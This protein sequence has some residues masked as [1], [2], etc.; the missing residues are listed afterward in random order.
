MFNNANERIQEEYLKKLIEFRNS[1]EQLSATLFS[2]AIIKQAAE[3][4]NSLLSTLSSFE[5]PEDNLTVNAHHIIL[6]LLKLLNALPIEKRFEYESLLLPGLNVLHF[7]L[8]RTL[9]KL[10]HNPKFMRDL[11]P[12]FT[13]FIDPSLHPFYAKQNAS[14]S[15]PTEKEEVYAPR[16]SEEVK[17]VAVQC[18]SLT[19]PAQYKEG[20]YLTSFQQSP[21]A[22]LLKKMKEEGEE[23]FLQYASQAIV[24]LLNAAQYGHDLQL[25]VDA[26]R[27][28]S[29]MLLDNIQDIDILSVVIPGTC[30]KLMAII[31]Q[32]PEKESHQVMCSTLDILGELITAVFN[33][34]KNQTLIN[35]ES[36]ANI[37]PVSQVA[38]KEKTGQKTKQQVRSEAWYAKARKDLRPLLEKTLQ[39]RYY[40]DWHTR[41]AFIKFSYDVLK[42]CAR[43]LDNCIQ[44]LM[45]M[46][47]LH[48]DDGYDQVANTCQLYMDLLSTAPSFENT[49]IPILKEELYTWMMKLP[50]YLIKR[51]EQEKIN[52]IC[53]VTGLL[54]LLREE[55]ESTLS[56]ALLRASDG[57]MTAL[58]FDEDN[59][60]IMEE[61]QQSNKLVEFQ[62]HSD[63]PT[64]T[65]T[66]P[67]YPKIRFKYVIQDSTTNKLTRLL[68]TIG[69]YC[70]LPI[71]ISHFMRYL[72]DG[73]KECHDPQA[74]FIVHS[75]LSGASF[76]DPD[77]FN[78]TLAV[79]WISANEDISASDVQTKKVRKVATQLFNDVMELLAQ[80]T[81]IIQG[82]TSLTTPMTKPMTNKLNIETE[83]ILTT[84][85]TLKLVNLTTF[86]LG[87]SFVEDQLIYILY[88][89]FSY[90]GSTHVY[91]HTYSLITLESIASLCDTGSIS[92]LAIHNIDYIINAISQ[93]ISVINSNL[94]LP[95]VLK[96]L[97]HVGGYPCIQYL[98]D[99]VEEIFDVLEAYFHN[100][101]L[102]SELCGVLY[103]IVLALERHFVSTTKEGK[104][105]ESPAYFVET[106]QEQYRMSQEVRS[107]IE[108]QKTTEDNTDKAVKSMEE[109]GKYFLEKQQKGLH[110][111]LTLEQSLKDQ[112]IPIDMP[113][114]MEEEG[115]SKPVLKENA[116]NDSRPL[117]HEQEMAK[118]IMM[119]ASHFLT[120]SSPQLRS[121]ILV[122]LTAGVTILSDNTQNLNPFVHQLWSIIVN[123]FDDPQN[124][125]VMN[126]ALLVEK[127]SELSTDFLSEKFTKDLWPK[128][129][130][131]L[132]KG[133]STAMTD[134][135]S[136]GYSIYSLY[137][138]TQFSVIKTLTKI[139]Y[140]VPLK[141][142]LVKEILE[143]T[144]FFF[145]EA[146]HNRVHVQLKEACQHLLHALSMQQPD[147][148]W[149]YETAYL[150]NND[151]AT[152][153][154]TLLDSLKVPAWFKFVNM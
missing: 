83:H 29:Q 14:A 65:A 117:S 44:P 140:N 39:L 132:R 139:A 59:L 48:M 154:S 130:K 56:M 69:K 70:D 7:V 4:L 72:S 126:A 3:L 26:L 95:L 18:L 122:L 147:T 142:G 146:N 91:I 149:L 19:L 125:V 115:T 58:K 134:T 131:V 85:L 74:A 75:L 94:R 21:S 6:P 24:A 67:L 22:V 1:L 90:L 145:D 98:D 135:N 47:L 11:I 5:N 13:Y 2:R 77:T 152:S 46:L 16:L 10:L 9:I 88:P 64:S 15:S 33:D 138:K 17:H 40:P 124:Y 31:Y 42:G 123:R 136:T 144:K 53:L 118:K 96:A 112:N 79:G 99:T 32:K 38:N 151:Y 35:F 60:N 114:D 116:K 41:F 86:I 51:G 78:T 76:N 55:A 84:C 120:A 113:E 127:I 52:A 45:E 128:F 129:Q 82:S 143:A 8:S 73:L 101:W 28:L 97:I 30:S 119:N 57:W 25:R 141:H 20:R 111:N 150:R 109:I 66:A 62:L 121:Q 71:W 43:T 107:F 23:V 102:T 103:E 153:P 93:R 106:V 133:V 80:S 92:E 148:V 49:M 61:S 89:L 87:R 36:F 27:T 37:F 105:N 81:L 50:G 104:T 110:D 68:N 63:T 34:E 108:K 100:E 54:I 137:H 12:F